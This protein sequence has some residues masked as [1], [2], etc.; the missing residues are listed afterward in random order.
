MPVEHRPTASRPGTPAAMLKPPFHLRIPDVSAEPA[1]AA[2]QARPAAATLPRDPIAEA[3]SKLSEKRILESQ[4]QVSSLIAGARDR[5][6]RLFG[7]LWAASIL[8]TALSIVA[9]AVELVQRMDFLNPVGDTVQI[10]NQ[11]ATEGPRGTPATATSGKPE[12]KPAAPREWS[13]Q[14][15]QKGAVESAVYE[16]DRSG[17]KEGAWL[18][19]TIS[20]N[21]T[22]KPLRGD[23]HDD[24]QPRAD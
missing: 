20:D 6:R 4:R 9:L 3:R 12:A 23:V 11:K 21:E 22:D 2:P 5:R 14:L 19:G 7:R 1:S 15:P 13:N 18:P 17:R 8:L 10:D 24:H 16:T